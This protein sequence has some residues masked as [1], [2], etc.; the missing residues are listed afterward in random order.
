MP[1]GSKNI[2]FKPPGSEPKF[3]GN[4]FMEPEPSDIEVE[5]ENDLV[6]HDALELS[7]PMH[8]HRIRLNE[9][10]ET[11]KIERFQSNSADL[12][13]TPIAE[14]KKATAVGKEKALSF[15]Q[16]D[17]N[18]NILTKIYDLGGEKQNEN[19][20]L[21]SML[22]T[23]KEQQ[24]YMNDREDLQ[25][26][27]ENTFPLKCPFESFQLFR[28]RKLQ[29][30]HSVLQSG[31]AV[32]QVRVYVLTGAKLTPL[33]QGNLSDPY[34]KV[35]LG[36]QVINNR[37]KYI[38]NTLDPKFYQ[39]FEFVTELPGPSLLTIEAWDRDIIFDEQIGSTVIDLEDRWY[40]QRW[41][42]EGKKF[43]ED[44]RLI[45]IKKPVENRWLWL[46]CSQN[47][48][49]S[50][51]LWVDILPANEARQFPK[52]IIEPPPKSKFEVRFVIWKTRNIP[53]G[54]PDSNLT[55]MFIRIWIGN[56]THQDTD[57]HWRAQK[58]VGNFN[59]R[60]KFP[61][62]LPRES[63]G[64]NVV[65]I[66]VWDKDIL[67]E[68]DLLCERL[69]NFDTV[70]GNAVIMN[71]PFNVFETPEEKAPE[72][73]PLS[74]ASS[75]LAN[76][77]TGS[78]RA[79]FGQN[80]ITPSEDSIN[81]QSMQSSGGYATMIS[82]SA[83]TQPRTA[84]NSES[85]DKGA[86]EDTHLLGNK[87][88]K[89]KGAISASTK[90]RQFRRELKKEQKKKHRPKKESRPLWHRV[91]NAVGMGPPPDDSQW[92][93]L[94]VVGNEGRPAHVTESQHQREKESKENP[95]V[96]ISVE[97]LPE[98]YA[99]AIPVGHGRNDP[100]TRPYLAAP[101]GRPDP[102]QMWNPFYLCWLFLDW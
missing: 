96:C 6:G 46:P 32:V 41:R 93:D 76:I 22:D 35:K 27:L 28:G 92:I 25:E 77:L 21:Q 38:K 56:D 13:L 26:E 36:D 70:F 15:G 18:F 64:D 82:M 45:D 47:Q 39:T 52:T 85:K 19:I 67:E 50:I 59:W 75:P 29:K 69:L 63:E 65:H 7:D 68:N 94:K 1:D 5:V 61:M 3:K 99:K 102:R 54:D 37:D 33:D 95:G 12:H 20:G 60:M 2:H 17:G 98:Q 40:S 43:N 83:S 49:G 89:K 53:A 97:I 90:D 23:I 101:Q 87:G 62:E 78:P 11:V 14:G 81:Y 16:T 84:E 51:K 55:D 58:G 100:N 79:F 74:K 9:A 66:Q 24:G 88:L 34:L 73:K 8:E 91:S 57:I 48:Q 86:K 30:D 10:L 4:P 72:E 31:T 80:K 71:K 44:L 42:K